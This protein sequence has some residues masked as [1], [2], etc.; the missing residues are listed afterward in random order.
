MAFVIKNAVLKDKKCI[1]NS[2][3]SFKIACKISLFYGSQ[4]IFYTT[5]TTLTP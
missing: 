1:L 2:I 3:L 4:S 5:M